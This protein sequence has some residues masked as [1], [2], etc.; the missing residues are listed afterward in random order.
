MLCE[1]C[2]SPAQVVER[3]TTEDASQA[4]KFVS[5]IN[6]IMPVIYVNGEIMI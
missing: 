2:L 5:E 4:S 3:R 6:E 1:V